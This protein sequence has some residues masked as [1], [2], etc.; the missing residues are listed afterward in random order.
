MFN[1]VVLLKPETPTIKG[2]L[3]EFR[4]DAFPSIDFDQIKALMEGRRVIFTYPG[5]EEEMIRSLLELKPEYVDLDHL[6]PSSFVK[7]VRQKCK[8]ICSYHN[9]E[10]TPEDLSSIP[11]FEA[12]EHKIA[13]M[14]NSTLD[15][16]RMLHYIKNKTHFTGI[17]MGE[18]GR[19]T[20][21]V[22]AIVGSTFNFIPA[23]KPSAPG[24]LT[25]DELIPCHKN[26]HIYGLIGDPVTFSPSHITH[27]A[28]FKALNLND[29]YVKMRVRPDEL[30]SFFDLLK[31]LPFYG[32]S[33]TIPH[34]EKVLPGGVFN[35]LKKV[36]G[37]WEGKNTD[38]EGALRAIEKRMSV[39]GKKILF[40]GSGGAARGIM[41][42]AE[43]R[44]AEIIF[45]NRSPKENMPF[46][47]IFQKEPYDILINTTPVYDKLPLEASWIDEGTLVFDIVARP[48]ETA[49]IK[50]A[51]QKGCSVIYGEEM[52]VYQAA[53]QFEWWF[54]GC[55]DQDEVTRVLFTSSRGDR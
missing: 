17:C 21:E 28:L 5:A 29:I 46:R 8:V 35:T 33:V 13:T 12:D 44:G 36:G 4:L 37:H 50:E 22:G 6:T 31:G 26:T 14:A 27:N 54:D 20:R 47:Q 23:G 30:T 18:E 55:L 43:K 51:K 1:V 9:F 34:K 19:L 41:E 49:L 42:A 15:A 11:L 2:D 40:I 32:L 48:R 52:F 3:Y 39:E 7:E 16:L 10:N 53:L 45:Y 25:F 38:G 24:Q